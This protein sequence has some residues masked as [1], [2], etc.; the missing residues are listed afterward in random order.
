MD[1]QIQRIHSAVIDGRAQNPR[2]IQ[3][4]LSQLYKALQKARPVIHDAIC[5]D[6]GYSSA[7][8]DTEIYL[9]INAV[10]QQYEAINFRKFIDQEYSIARGKDNPHKRVPIG[11][12]YIIPSNHSLL[13]SIISPVCAAIAA[14]NCV[15]IEV[16]HRALVRIFH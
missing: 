14:G 2:Y 9:A 13:Y 4:Q 16:R 7:E 3:K 8:A 1:S 11:C 10:K 5:Q 15:V 6:S 12:V